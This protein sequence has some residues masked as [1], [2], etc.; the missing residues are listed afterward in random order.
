MQ[1]ELI[2][3]RIDRPPHR[4]LHRRILTLPAM[5]HVFAGARSGGG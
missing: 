5:P 4:R 1:D 2:A 3:I